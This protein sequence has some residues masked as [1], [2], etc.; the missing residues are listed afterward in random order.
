MVIPYG[1]KNFDGLS[2]ITLNL[3][4][5]KLIAIFQP[6]SKMASSFCLAI[7]MTFS[8]ILKF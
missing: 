2:T 1:N 8:D 5:K 6:V 3:W 7:F 4:E